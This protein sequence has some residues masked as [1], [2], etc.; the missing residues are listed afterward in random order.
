VRK[1]YSKKHIGHV[2]CPPAKLACATHSKFRTL[3]IAQAVPDRGPHDGQNFVIIL[4]THLQ[5][6]YDECEGQFNLSIGDFPLKELAHDDTRILAQ[7]PALDKGKTE[8]LIM[9]AQS[10]HATCMGKKLEDTLQISS[11]IPDFYTFTSRTYGAAWGMASPAIALLVLGALASF[12][13]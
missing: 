8:D 6:Y 2:K 10:L 7:F 9:V 13:I 12:F 4:G 11:T 1:L 3:D 5:Q